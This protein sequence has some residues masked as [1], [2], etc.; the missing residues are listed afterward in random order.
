MVE[1]DARTREHVVALAV[2]DRYPVAIDLGHAIGAARIEGRL[3]CLR[4]FLHMA[5]HLA[6]R[7]LV[8]A[9]G[10]VHQAQRL[11]QAGDPEARHLAREQRL[12]PRGGHERLR[13]EVVHLGGADI[14]HGLNH[15]PL[16]RQVRLH[17]GN[18]ILDVADALELFRAR[19]TH[20]AVHVVAL[21]QQKL[22]QVRTV[23]PGDAC[24]QR[25]LRP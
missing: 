13:R 22:R 19:T 23:L 8:K 12:V 5:E 17:Q 21:F 4:R 20:H 1:Q 6:R 7:G 16:V 15:R 10:L 2:I 3:F 24:N 14:A 9:D 25:T 11:K 18:S